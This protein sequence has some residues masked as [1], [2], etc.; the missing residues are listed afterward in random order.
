MISDDTTIGQVFDLQR[1]CTHD[2][3]GI[4][5]TVFLKGCPLRCVWCHNPESQKPEPEL[6]FIERSCIDCGSCGDACAE[7]DPRVLLGQRSSDSGDC[8]NELACA[9]ACPTGAIER[10][11]RSLTVAEVLVEIEKD[12]VFYEESGGGVTLSGGEPMMQYGFTKAL[13]ASARAA[14][15]HT[16]LET[17]G[18]GPGERYEDVRPMVGL[19]LWDVKDTDAKRHR[20]LT[21]VDMEPLQ[22]NLRRIDAAGAKTVLRCL[23][24]ANVNL[25]EA[26]L[27]G[28]A[29]VYHSL[30]HCAGVELLAYHPLGDAKREQLGLEPTGHK[31][32]IPSSEQMARARQTLDR[33]GVLKPAVAGDA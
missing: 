6:F 28:I 20:R 17:S 30:T 14:E 9:D 16:C 24:M 5:T 26:H 11:G 33:L 4:R 10:V 7:G 23:L 8:C 22:A 29:R 1:F 25:D 27:E 32:W 19:F 31:E 13:L 3:P 18:W 2:G 15:I 21:G 12:R